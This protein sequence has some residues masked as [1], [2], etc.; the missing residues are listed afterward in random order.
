MISDDT[1]NV[2]KK[3]LNTRN[4][5]NEQ[6]LSDIIDSMRIDI[7]GLVSAIEENNENTDANKQLLYALEKSCDEIE[8]QFE[9]IDYWELY[10]R[11]NK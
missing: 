11:L 4:E 9:T 7:S 2:L 8:E 1:I 6:V 5:I 3:Y 10:L